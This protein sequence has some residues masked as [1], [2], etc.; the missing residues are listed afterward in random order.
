MPLIKA[1]RTAQ[2]PMVAEFTFN[3][4]DTMVD[5][6]G[7]TKTFGS[8]FGDQGTFEVIP[9]PL[10]AVV[11]GVDLIVETAGAGPTAYTVS[12][13]TAASAAN[14]LAATSVLTAGRTSATT[15]LS[16]AGG[17]LLCNNGQNIRIA[18]ASTVANAT[19]GKFRVRV[20]YTIDAR[21]HEVVTA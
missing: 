1:N 4:N 12:V 6:N 3:F 7:V 15:T 16:A 17:T 2:F 11:Q 18:I 20:A 5:V 8:V 19:A 9:M 21:A 14:L 13:G 10:G